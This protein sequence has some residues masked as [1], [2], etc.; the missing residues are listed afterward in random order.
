MDNHIHLSYV[1]AASNFGFRSGELKCGSAFA[2][3]V[4]S[5]LTADFHQRLNLSGALDACWIG[6]KEK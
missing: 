1:Q 3:T 2:R 5:K 6:G 4:K